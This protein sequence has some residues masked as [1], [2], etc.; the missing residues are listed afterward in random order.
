VQHRIE[1]FERRET[2]ISLQTPEQTDVESNVKKSHV[3]KAIGEHDK[4]T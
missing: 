1:F 4:K 2:G 3:D